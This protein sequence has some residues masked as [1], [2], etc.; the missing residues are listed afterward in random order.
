MPVDAP[1]T[2]ARAAQHLDRRILAAR[3]LMDIW[4][5]LFA[6][7][8]FDHFSSFLDLKSV[9][10]SLNKAQ[11]LCHVRCYSQSAAASSKAGLVPD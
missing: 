1:V 4:Y 10:T 8:L 6:A 3:P 9:L 5:W 11:L 2:T 7:S